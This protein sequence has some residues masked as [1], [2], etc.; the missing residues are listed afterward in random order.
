MACTHDH[1]WESFKRFLLVVLCPPFRAAFSPA[2][3]S[4]FVWLPRHGWLAVNKLNFERIE[5]RLALPMLAVTLLVLPLLAAELFLGA[6]MEQHVWAAIIVHCL[7]AIVWFSFALEF[8]ITLALSEKKLAYCK[9]HWINIAII[10]LPLL[11]F[12]RALRLL[13]ITKATKLIR[14]YRMRG[15]VARTMRFAMVF[16]LI[17]RLMERNPEK[18]LL[19]LEDKVSEK[20]AEITALEEKMSELRARI[21][22]DKEDAPEA[23]KTTRPVPAEPRTF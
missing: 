11:A 12:L 7:T 13:R 22:K 20:K 1:H 14:A 23:E 15:V 8:I 2:Y 5:L 16:N 3:C 19:S 10:I 6:W 21:A 9:I 17:E 4:R 18:Y